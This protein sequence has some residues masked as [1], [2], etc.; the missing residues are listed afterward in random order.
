MSHISFHPCDNINRLFSVIFKDSQV[1]SSMALGRTKY[2]YLI[3]F[4]LAPN[5][6]SVLETKI[7][8]SP[9]FVIF[10]EIMNGCVNKILE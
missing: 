8:A 2:S 9:L 1:A 5:F 6:K 4:G 3:N 7:Y 10:D